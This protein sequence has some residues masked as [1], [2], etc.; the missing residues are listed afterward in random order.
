M[1]RLLLIALLALMTGGCAIGNQH[2]YAGQPVAIASGAGKPVAL[3]VVDARPYVVSGHKA[4]NF[5]GLQRGGFANPFDVTTVSGKP[6][7]EDFQDTIATSLRRNGTDV[8]PVT[9]PPGAGGDAARAALARTGA[10]RAILLRLNE[11]KADSMVSASLIYDVRLDVLDRSGESL[12]G[13]NAAGRDVLGGN[14]MNGPGHAN[15]AVP[16]AYR[17]RLEQLFA[18]PKVVA[19]LR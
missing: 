7:A 10:E 9:L 5:V 16:A 18:D 14:F 4:P 2:Q 15:E 1:A 19:A 12:G 17:R 3:A 11:W 13:T 8:R 6:M